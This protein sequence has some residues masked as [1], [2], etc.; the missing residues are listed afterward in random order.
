M[1]LSE[2]DYNLIVNA[3]TIAKEQWAK[4]SE[5]VKAEAARLAEQFDHQVKQATDLIDKIIDRED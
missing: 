2:S 4:D 1:T 5:K 3:L